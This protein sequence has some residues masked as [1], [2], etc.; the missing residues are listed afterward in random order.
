MM[1][2]TA[3]PRRTSVRCPA[4]C[5][6]FAQRASHGTRSGSCFIAC[7]GRT[8][9]FVLQYLDLAVITT[10]LLARPQELLRNRSTT[11]PAPP[12][13][14]PRQKQQYTSQ[15]AK[16][17]S[18]LRDSTTFRRKRLL[19]TNSTNK[20]HRHSVNRAETFTTTTKQL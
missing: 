7:C 1:I 14:Q 18:N 6:P 17:E 20:R 15:Q 2:I 13:F 3:P 19:I 5:N 9:A 16:Q 10:T 12:S 8:A 4:S 11:L